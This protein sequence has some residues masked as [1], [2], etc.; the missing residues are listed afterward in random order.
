MGLKAS[1]SIDIAIPKDRVYNS[2]YK[3]RGLQAFFGQG[4]L[5]VYVLAAGSACK[6]ELSARNTAASGD[7]F[8]YS[9][10]Q[11]PSSS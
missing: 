9:C 2:S 8:N 10:I 7:R 3:E 5:S 4:N 11:D 1:S 6:L